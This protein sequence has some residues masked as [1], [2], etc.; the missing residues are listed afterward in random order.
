MRSKIRQ[1]GINDL[2]NGLMHEGKIEGCEAHQFV[3]LK[4]NYIF[5]RFT[6]TKANN[7]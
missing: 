5:T 7:S 6:S 1:K 4:L 2:E 3:F